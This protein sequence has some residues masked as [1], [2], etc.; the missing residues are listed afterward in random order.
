MYFKCIISSFLLF[1]FSFNVSEAQKNA[2]VFGKV[3][4]MTTKELLE[5]TTVAQ[6]ST[7]NGT[8]VDAKGEYT[9]RVPTF[10]KM[11][12]IV[13]RVGYKDVTV[14]IPSLRP[15]EK[16]QVDI[17]MSSSEQTGEVEVRARRIDDVGIVREKVTELKFIPNASGNF[18][19]V[20]PS[21]ALGTNAGSGGELSSQYNVRGGNYD[22]NLVYVNDFEIYRP[23]LVRA[24]QQEGLSFPNIDMISNIAFSSGGFEAKYGDKLS[25]VL[26]IKYKRPD[27]LRYSIGASLLGGS[28]H[29]EG[30][31]KL[32]KTGYR[33]FRYLVGARYKTTKYL[34]TSQD[35]K[36]EYT[37]NFGDIQTYL[38]FDMSKNWQ[39]AFLGNINNSVFNFIPS[40]RSSVSGVINRTLQ[41]NVKYDGAERDNFTTALAGLS[42]NYIPENRRNPLYLKF[43]A[44]TYTSQENERI[45]ITGDY[46]L[47]E[48]DTN[49]GS[50]KVGEV[51]GEVGSGTQQL[52]VRNYLSSQV[53][54]VEHKGGIEF[55]RKG[56]SDTKTNFIQWSVRLQNEIIKDKLKEWER[57]DSAL[58]SLNFDTSALYVQRY[59]ATRNSLNT[60]RLQAS[61]Q[62]TYTLRH[63][64]KSE[65]QFSLGVRASYW[66]FNKE[67]TFTPRAQILF[68]PLSWSKDISFRLAGGLFYQPPFYRELRNIDGLVSNNV[69]SQKSAHIVFGYTQDFYLGKN[70]KKFRF[71]SEAYYKSMW[72]LISYDIDNVRIRYSGLND[73]KGYATGLDM[74]LNGEF[75]EGAESWINFSFLRTRETLNG[76]QHRIRKLG[77]PI[78]TDVKDVPRPS[79]RF[80]N[81]SMFFQDYWRSNKNFKMHLNFTVGSG[82]P[83]GIPYNNVEYRNTYRFKPYHRV[84]IGFSYLLWDQIMKD[85]K[86]RNLFRFTRTSWVSFEVF[87][88]MQ[89][90]N[91]AGNTWVKTVFKQ[92][93]RVA[94]NL[95]TRRLNLR[96]KMDF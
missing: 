86:P 76:V 55:T 34:L 89:V 48:I 94:N 37:P 8:S 40:Q 66:D 1:V 30:S 54:N 84:D 92:Q 29:L 44:S 41:L 24:G 5:F 47:Q 13:S 21:I 31:R 25:S 83:F 69:R 22:E 95:T 93:Y 14:E 77:E 78:G 23:Q 60:N 17:G 96:L 36:G 81:M 53:T 70:P 90:Q 35:V 85:K 63:D 46:V 4:D 65:L 26:D 75:V 91:Q 68:K 79:D 88:L 39:L 12:I 28:A 32:D 38:T 27:S 58:Y 71:I 16:Y 67:A 80:F 9:L 11:Q 73:S 74:R 42:L 20:L 56:I 64:E 43:L 6:K 7:S 52:F 51:I 87:N 15:N 19:S 61:F 62:D 10:T 57:I 18:E 2:V 82:L 50:D 72:D 33:R 49:L 3:I 59:V 45:D